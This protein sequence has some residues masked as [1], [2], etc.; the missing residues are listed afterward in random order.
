[1][2][3]DHPVTGP[4]IAADLDLADKE[5]LP[6]IDPEYHGQVCLARVEQLD[7]DGRDSVRALLVDSN[8]GS[9]QLFDGAAGVE[10]GEALAFP[11]HTVDVGGLELFL[12][13]ATEI[14]VAGVIEHDVD[15]VRLVGGAEEAS[16][17]EE[18]SEGEADHGSAEYGCYFFE[19]EGVWIW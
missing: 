5:V 6:F 10:L 12:S 2:P 13:I 16:F 17:E 18:D 7:R 1:M 9:A 8:Q 3:A 11:G 15:K 4:G 14:T 19:G